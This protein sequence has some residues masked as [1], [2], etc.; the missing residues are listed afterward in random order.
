MKGVTVAP[1]P[2]AAEAGARMLEQG[3][4]AFDA[5]IAAA[6]MQMVVDPFMCGPGGMGTGLFFNSSTGES[7]TIDFHGRAGSRVTPK[8]WQAD[9]KGRTAI[10]GYTLF[11]DFRSELGYTSITTPGTI[12]GFAEVHKRYATRPWSELLEPAIKKARDGVLISPSFS[13]FLHRTPQPGLPD[14]RRRV[15]SSEA[16]ER[17]YVKADGSLVKA[18]DLLRNPDMATTLATLAKEGP[19][20]MYTGQLSRIIAK[21]LE[22]NGSFITHN[23]L[24]SYRV[25]SG[26]PLK[27]R[28]RGFTVA[29]NLPPGGG[30]WL[31]EVLNILEGFPLSDLAHNGPEHLHVLATAM[32]LA[33]GDRDRYLGDPDYVDVPIDE[34]FVSK[35]HAAELQRKIRSN[36]ET[37]SKSPAKAGSETT[38]LAVVDEDGNVAAI[39]HTLGTASGVVTPGLG[40]LYNNSMKLFDPVPGNANS[41][42]AGKARTTGMSPTT[43]FKDNRPVLVVGAPGGSVIMSAVLQSISN[44]ID[45]GMTAT[46][47]VSA[48]RIHTEGGAVYIEARVREDICDQLRKRDHR[49]EHVVESYSPTFSKAQMVRL[50]SDGRLDGASD[51]RGGGGVAYAL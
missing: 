39:T 3:G 10:S 48:P 49:V 36:E 14:G 28:Y 18:G 31:L 11:D 27:V 20:S 30:P 17:I 26:T 15:G 43:V 12:A 5:V 22:S 4:N 6:F 46:E 47:A 25:R 21:D 35:D 9:M 50:L 38:H 16:C 37:G 34:L 7:H 2:G 41:I 29:S 24:V 33:H 13:D 1:Q 40:F 44:V 19:D 42:A 51:P 8:M 23:D 32:K 45:F